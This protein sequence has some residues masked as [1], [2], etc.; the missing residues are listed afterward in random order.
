VRYSLSVTTVTTIYLDSIHPIQSVATMI[1][2]NM[3]SRL[4]R[5]PFV[6][7]SAAVLLFLWSAYI[8]EK[9]LQ[10]I[11]GFA[12]SDAE[13]H[14]FP[15]ARSNSNKQPIEGR[16]PAEVVDELWRRANQGDLLTE[17]GWET[18]NAFFT[19]PLPFPGTNKIKVVSNYWGPASEIGSDV[20]GVEVYLGFLDA[21]E[22][23]GSLRYTPPPKPYTMKMALSYRLMTMPA[24]DRWYG[25][26]GKLVEKKPSGSRFWQIK[27]KPGPPMATVNT[28]IRYVLE[29]RKQTHNPVIRE[30]ADRTLAVLEQWR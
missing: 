29:T 15:I 16:K 4:R 3:S 6:V 24:Y 28:A 1:S 11:R 9:W 23:D 26:D 25:P 17:E 10:Q 14:P 21:G 20:D 30:N 5:G 27:G 18:T 8:P 22:I 2:T 12:H 13:R 19:E 7:L